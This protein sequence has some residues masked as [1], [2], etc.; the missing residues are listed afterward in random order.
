[1]KA[2][3]IIK[4]LNANYH[5]GSMEEAIFLTAISPVRQNST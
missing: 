1:M 2:E 3:R 5:F 4:I